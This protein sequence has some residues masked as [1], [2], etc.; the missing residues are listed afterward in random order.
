MRDPINPAIGKSAQ[1]GD[2]RTNYFEGAQ[3]EGA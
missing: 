2:I 1:A 3:V